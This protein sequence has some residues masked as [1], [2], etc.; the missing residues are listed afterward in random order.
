MRRPTMRPATHLSTWRWR[1]GSR[2]SDVRLPVLGRDFGEHGFE[3]RTADRGKHTADRAEP[4]AEHA[5]GDHRERI[6][7]HVYRNSRCRVL[8][9]GDDVDP[10]DGSDT[11]QTLAH[12]DG[13]PRGPHAQP[14]VG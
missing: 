10:D 9:H 6:D 8:Q 4:V 14:H 11:G 2:R 5:P 13:W 7:E 3:D 1:A 12:G